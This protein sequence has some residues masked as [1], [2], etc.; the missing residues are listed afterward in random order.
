[1][2]TSRSCPA[3]LGQEDSGNDLDSPYIIYSHNKRLN[4]IFCSPEE[5]LPPLENSS[6]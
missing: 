1:M 3:T 2:A 6:P 5:E 4:E